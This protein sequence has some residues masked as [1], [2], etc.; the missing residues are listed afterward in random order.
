MKKIILT[1]LLTSLLLSASDLQNIGVEVTYTDSND[2]EK[3]ILIK[4]E[5]P[6]NCKEIKFS[7]KNILGGSLWSH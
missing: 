4:R 2:N 3:N 5:K 1:S 6:E 7:P